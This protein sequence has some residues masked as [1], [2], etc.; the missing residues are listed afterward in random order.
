MGASAHLQMGKLSLQ[1]RGHLFK[2]TKSFRAG[3]ARP[4]AYLPHLP[5]DICSRGNL[6]VPH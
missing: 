6:K 3:A 2:V 1:Q 5:A 4:K